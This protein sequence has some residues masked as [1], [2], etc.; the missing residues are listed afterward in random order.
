[1]SETALLAAHLQKPFVGTEATSVL[2]VA[3]VASRVARRCVDPGPIGVKTA[4]VHPATA[5]RT[6]FPEIVI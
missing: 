2:T 1:M 6:T 3:P 5:S 4:Q